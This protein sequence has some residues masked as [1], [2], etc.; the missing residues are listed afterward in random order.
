MPDTPLLA[1][2]RLDV[3]MRGVPVLEDVSF[4][5]A[6]GETLGL[7]G[8]AGCGKSVTALSIMRLLPN[9]PRSEE[10]TSELQSH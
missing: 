1:V 5:I 9:P 7:V 4:Q 10:H 6:P 8:E 3:T 2:E